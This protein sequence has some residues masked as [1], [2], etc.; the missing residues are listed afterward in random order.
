MTERVARASASRPW[1]VLGGWVLAVVLIGTLLGDALTNQ[2][3]VTRPTDSKRGQELLAARMGSGSEPSEV[4][5]VRSGTL[6]A[7]DPAFKDEIRLLLQAALAT[8]VLDAAAGA[9]ARVEHLP[10]SP[11]RDAVLVALPM[12]TDDVECW[13][14]WSRPHGQVRSVRAADDKHH[15]RLTTS[16]STDIRSA[17]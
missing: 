3:E 13:W 8:G 6:T 11:D 15:R 17:V 16:A 9:A 2:T 1:R 12:R 7:D 4:V 14:S 10:V 5:V